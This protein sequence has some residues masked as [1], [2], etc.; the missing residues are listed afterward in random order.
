MRPYDFYSD[1]YASF[2]YKHDFD[3]Y[4][5]RLKFSKPFVS[6]V[7]NLMYGKLSHESKAATINVTA[8]VSGYHESGLLLNQLLQKNFFHTIYIYLNVGAMYHW[9]SSFDW[10]KNGLFVIGISG[11]F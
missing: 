7:H 5:W 1:G 11:G 3:K 2:M 8:P 10:K 9:T 4:F 6:V